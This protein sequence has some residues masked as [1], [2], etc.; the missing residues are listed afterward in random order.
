MSVLGSGHRRPLRA[1]DGR[2][3]FAVGSSGG[4]LRFIVGPM[5]PPAYGGLGALCSGRRVRCFS[6][7]GFAPSLLG[8]HWLPTTI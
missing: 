8:G 7:L 1:L 6:S 3:H 5:V 2:L 4:W